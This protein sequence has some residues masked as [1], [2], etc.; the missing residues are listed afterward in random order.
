[1]LRELTLRNYRGFEN[2]VVDLR[3]LTVAVGYNN[4]GKS[5]VV[6]ALR[7]VSIITERLGGLTFRDPPDW[8]GLGRAARGVRPAIDG[9]GINTALI[10]HR[11][12]NEPAEVHAQFTTGERIEVRVSPDGACFALL[13]D[14]TGQAIRSQAV[15]RSI[16]FPTLH[17]LPQISPLEPEES[18]LTDDYVRRHMSSP[19]SSRHFRNQLRLLP[20]DYQRFRELASETWPAIQIVR[21]GGARG[22]HGDQLVLEVRDRDFVAEVGAMGHGL[23]MWLQ[24]VWFLCRTAQTAS[25]VLDEPDVYMHP[26]LQRRLIRYVKSRFRQVIIATH[27]VEIMADLAPSEILIID[28]RRARSQFADTAPA[29]Q[30]VIETLG[31]VHNIHLAR[32]W[33]ARRCLL[34]EGDDLAFLKILHEKLFPQAAT[35]LDDIP[36]VSIGGWAGWPYAIGSSMFVRNAFGQAITVYCLL[37]RDYH[38]PSQIAERQG[39]AQQRDVELHIWGRKEIENYFIV[40]AA[41]A[42][43]LCQRDPA[44]DQAQVATQVSGQIDQIVASLEND[45]FDAFSASFLQDDRAGGG[46]QANRRARAH[47]DAIRVLPSGLQSAASGKVIVQR[48]SGWAHQQFGR[49]FGAA[50]VVRAMNVAE[51]ADEVIDVLRSIERRRSFGRPTPVV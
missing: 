19:L 35:S 43:L 7:L 5:T 13:R 8:T 39:D 49:G 27:S 45:M 34:V 38:T 2:H 11:Y 44:L 18:I 32:L 31:G 26:D 28:R 48:L 21:L 6:E 20:G 25:V 17:V 22:A 47:I 40:P 42:R 15:A 37:D 41:I 29:V 12:S 24:T 50:D 51:I 3:P 30:R 10:T 9:L 36:N 16:A 1:M 23:Q 33:D 46:T 14:R 4:A